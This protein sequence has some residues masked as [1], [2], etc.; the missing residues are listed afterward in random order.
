MKPLYWVLIGVVIL[1]VGFFIYKSNQTKKEAQA[2][3]AAA[4]LASANNQPGSLAP[5][6]SSQVAQI[7]G[8]L[9]PYFE[10]SVEGGLIGNKK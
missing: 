4:A 9:F 7:I 5:G 10:T 3:A 8:S 6:G 2:A 1:I